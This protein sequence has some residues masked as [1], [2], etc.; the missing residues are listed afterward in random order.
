MS[1]ASASIWFFVIYQG[2]LNNAMHMY[3]KQVNRGHTSQNFPSQ[4]I[5]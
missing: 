2:E 1:Q 3:S 4:V 5:E